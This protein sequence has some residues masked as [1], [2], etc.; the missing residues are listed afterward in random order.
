MNTI[1]ILIV[2]L[3]ISFTGITIF[4]QN[5]S[6][7]RYLNKERF[8]Q[9]RIWLDSATQVFQEGFPIIRSIPPLSVNM[10]YDV[11]IGYVYL[12]SLLRFGDKKAYDSLYQSWNSLNDT[13]TGALKYLYII[14]DYDPAIFNQYANEV[15]FYHNR[16]P[17]LIKIIG[18]T[19][20]TPP[21]VGPY[22]LYLDRLKYK[23]CK[24]F[25]EI[26]SGSRKMAYY[27]MLYA[28]IILR[29]KI[30]NIDSMINKNSSLGYYSF[31]ATA[32][33]LDTL[34]GKIIPTYQMPEPKKSVPLSSALFNFQYTPYNYGMFGVVGHEPLYSR[35][36]TAFFDGRDFRMKIDQEAIIF[37]KFHDPKFDFQN[38]YFD[39]ELE[40]TCSLNALRIEN[41]VVFDINNVWS[42]QVEIPYSEWKQI[43]LNLLDDIYNSDY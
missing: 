20:T 38:D 22:N 12:D 21:T 24:K 6:G 35:R 9:Q 1:K 18:D 5:E 3:V 36:D 25:R 14:N 19:S 11:L 16:G 32:V 33:I 13:L 8:Q 31:N 40:Q 41:G 30:I 2:C 28:D 10:P 4:A 39:L 34:K 7:T 37:V 15:K 43:Y 27:S 29:V 42:E 26:Y 17:Q 23:S